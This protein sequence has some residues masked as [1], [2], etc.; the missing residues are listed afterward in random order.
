[1]H[2]ID[3]TIFSDHFSAFFASPVHR[4]SRNVT[5]PPFPFLC[6]KD[7]SEYS[8][9]S[10]YPQTVNYFRL[11]LPRSERRRRRRRRGVERGWSGAGS[12]K[13]HSNQGIYIP[14]SLASRKLTRGH[15]KTW[16]KEVYFLNTEGR[17]SVFLLESRIAI[18]KLH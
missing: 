10:L 6:G 13:L 7:R 8:I 16:L 18:Q 12:R 11:F 15:S 2:S 3:T 9:E 17:A 14:G 1:M 5:K 4:L